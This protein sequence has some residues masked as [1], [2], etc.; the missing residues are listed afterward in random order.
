[1]PRFDTAA[2]ILV[3]IQQGFEDP[4]WGVRNNPDAETNAARLLARWRAEGRPLF[5]VRHASRRPTAPLS[6]TGPGFAFKPEIAPL[7]GEPEIVKSVNSAFIGTDL[8]SQLR[9]AGIDTIVVAGLTTPHCVSTTTRMAGNLGFAAFV[10]ADACATFVPRE[11]FAWGGG[12]PLPADPELSH[13]YALAH[14]HGEFATVLTT[15]DILGEAP[16]QPQRSAAPRFYGA[17]RPARVTVLDAGHG[18]PL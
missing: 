8:E 14:L 15:G 6:P 3:D 4:T 13:A 10:A 7:P 12:A 18:A 1:M 9:A 17:M 11:G 5:H 2:L 16:A